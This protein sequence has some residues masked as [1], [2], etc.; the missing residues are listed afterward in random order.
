MI[1]LRF[2]T[3][4]KL[5]S[6]ELA[7]VERFFALT[8]DIMGLA[9]DHYSFEK[10]LYEFTSSGCI[11]NAACFIQRLHGVDTATAKSMLRDEV[12]RRDMS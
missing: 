1:W 2:A 7:S 8:I 4:I 5:S 10:D 3:D 9:N 6:E 12:Y 11:R